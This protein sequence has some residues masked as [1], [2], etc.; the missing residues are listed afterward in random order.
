M[1]VRPQI[2]THLE[3]VSTCRPAKPYFNRISAPLFTLRLIIG[4]RPPRPSSSILSTLLYE[5]R[6]CTMDADEVLVVVYYLRRKQKKRAK[7]RKYWVLPILRERFG[8][9]TFQNLITELRRDEI[10]F[11]N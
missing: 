8:L 1:Y 3:L 4:C 10:K 7:E 2:I 11:F 9:G 6:L 5:R